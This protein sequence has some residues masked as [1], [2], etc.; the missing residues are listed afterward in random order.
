MSSV[1]VL[2]P[3]RWRT[4][5][6]PAEPSSALKN[7][8]LGAHGYKF[9]RSSGGLHFWVH[10]EPNHRRLPQGSADNFSTR[11]EAKADAWSHLAASRKSESPS[12]ESPEHRL[13]A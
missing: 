10:C 5:P 8:L 11:G 6:I 9:F 13:A 12:V 2:A 3:M 4:A 1:A 7:N